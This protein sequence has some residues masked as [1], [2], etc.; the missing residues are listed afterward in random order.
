[1][2]GSHREGGVFVLSSKSYT[3]TSSSPVGGRTDVK[4]HHNEDTDLLTI[5]VSDERV[6]RTVEFD[7][8]IVDVDEAGNILGLEIFDASEVIAKGLEAASNPPLDTLLADRARA[9]LKEVGA[10]ISAETPA[11]D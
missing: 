7:F 5:V 6:A 4:I 2:R 9:L 3:G 10:R 1:L 11:A 8:G